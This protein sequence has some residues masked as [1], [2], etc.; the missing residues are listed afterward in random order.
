MNEIEKPAIVKRFGEDFFSEGG[1][2]TLPTTAIVDRPGVT[3]GREYTLTHKNGWTV[4]G[5]LIEDW[6]E[7][8]NDFEASHPTY[9]RVYGNFE[10]EVYADS[11]DGFQDFYENFTPDAWD[12]W[13][14]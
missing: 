8:V 9:G 13:D 5:V 4:T 12:Y 10:N 3:A 14:I 7:W 6:Y 1:A 2:L 11:E